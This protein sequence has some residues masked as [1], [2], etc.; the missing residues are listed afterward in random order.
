MFCENQK[1]SVDDIA[2]KLDVTRRTVLRDVQKIKKKVFLMYDK[3]GTM[4]VKIGSD[5]KV[6]QEQVLPYVCPISSMSIIQEIWERKS[7]RR[8]EATGQKEDACQE[9]LLMV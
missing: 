1:I 4:E 3:K 6:T 7:R 5:N 2:V 9:I 8:H